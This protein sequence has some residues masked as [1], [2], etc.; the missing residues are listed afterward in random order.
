MGRMFTSDAPLWLTLVALTQ[1]CAASRGD[2]QEFDGF[3]FTISFCRNCSILESPWLHAP[4]FLLHLEVFKLMFLPSLNK[5]VS[6][7][8]VFLLELSA[9]CV[10]EGADV[11]L[12]DAQK[13]LKDGGRKWM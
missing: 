9:R 13:T 8:T 10:I 12:T 5:F 11:I 1:G 4:F 6:R 2:H 7:F 3:M